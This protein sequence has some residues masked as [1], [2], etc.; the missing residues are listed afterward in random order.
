MKK[1][2]AAT[3]GLALAVNTVF[4]LKKLEP[5]DKYTP[6]IAKVMPAV[7]EIHVVGTMKERLP[8]S[9]GE[10]IRYLRSGLAAVLGSGA[11]ISSNG[12]ILTV[13]H[14]FNGFDKIV[15]VT[16]ISPAGD[17]VAAKIVQVGNG[18]DLAI[19]KVDFYEST[20]FVKIADPSKL[21]VG[22]EVIAIGSPAGLSF[23]ASKGII[24]ALY[25][26]FDG[27]YNVTQSDA[28]TNPGNSGGPMFNLDGELVGVVSFFVMVDHRFPVFTGLGFSVQCGQC[29]EFV[30]K[31]SKVLPDLKRALFKDKWG[32]LCRILKGY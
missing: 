25:R 23:S 1:L 17:E 18:V 26:D 31:A 7:V 28:A 24:S 14:L 22:Q 9:G 20:P 30:T 15:S 5:K 27:A 10:E 13:A 21:N 4:Y 2:I 16:V 19:I 11:Y 12:Y 8:F 3:L 6:V 29:I 32:L